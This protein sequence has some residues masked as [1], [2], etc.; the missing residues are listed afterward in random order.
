TTWLV[1]TA[2]PPESWASETT[3][4][5][6]PAT[7]VLPLLVMLAKSSVTWSARLGATITRTAS[8]P[9]PPRRAVRVMRRSLLPQGTGTRTRPAPVGAPGLP[10]RAVA[11]TV[12]VHVILCGRATEPPK[13]IPFTQPLLPDMNLLIPE[14]SLVVLVGPSGS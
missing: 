10:L 12:R 2:R 3:T 11:T 13:E 8:S 6:W 4:D 14:L 5:S 1:P 9:P 7:F